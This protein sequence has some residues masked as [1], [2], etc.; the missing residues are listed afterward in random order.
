MT[1]AFDVWASSGTLTFQPDGTQADG[2]CQLLRF[3]HGI[4]QAARE[5]IEDDPYAAAGL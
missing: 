3:S 1:T 4:G 5:Q 2:G